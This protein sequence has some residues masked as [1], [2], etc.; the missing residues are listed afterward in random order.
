MMRKK[1]AWVICV[2]ALLVGLVQIQQGTELA[3]ASSPPKTDFKYNNDDIGEYYSI[4]CYGTQNPNK[5]AF[6][7]L[8]ATDKIVTGVNFMYATD[9]TDTTNLQVY[10]TNAYT[11]YWADADVS[12]LMTLSSTA[13]WM[14]F[15]FTEEFI[16]GTS[17]FDVE[18]RSTDD[19][20]SCPMNIVDT[21]STG[22][23][24]HKSFSAWQLDT[25]GE[26]IVEMETEAIQPLSY[27][28]QQTGTINGPISDYIDCWKFTVPSATPLDVKASVTSGSAI[29]FSVYDGYYQLVSSMNKLGD[30]YSNSTWQEYQRAPQA[31][32]VTYYVLVRCVNFL[33][34]VA[35]YSIEYSAQAGGGVTD[36]DYEENDALGSAYILTAGSYPGLVCADDDWYRIYLN[37]GQNLTAYISFTHSLGDLDLKLYNSSGSLLNSSTSVNDWE[38]VSYAAAASG[39]YYVD[40]YRYSGS[41]SNDY[42]MTFSVVGGVS[43]DG[44]EDNDLFGTASPVSQNT[45]SGLVCADDDWYKIYV[46]S[47]N[48]LT[49][50]IAFTHS[51]GDLDLKLWQTESS[52]LNFS[53]STNNWERVTYEITTT[54][55][56]YVQVYRYT[57]SGSNSYTMTLG[58]APSSTDDIYEQNDVLEDAKTLLA[59][60]YSSLVC[61]D[62]DWFKIDVPAY[63]TLRVTVTFSSSGDDL[64]LKIYFASGNVAGVGEISSGTNTASIEVTEGGI[65]YI[66]VFPAGVSNNYSLNISTPPLSGGIAGFD[67]FVLLGVMSIV[68]SILVRKRYNHRN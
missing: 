31:S 2:A 5:V 38:R 23:S 32:S 3:T 66:K 4:F 35:S 10:V 44:F 15:S 47:G 11:S 28:V 16:A 34:G 61:A 63:S 42:D 60:S 1:Y 48:I 53:L 30:S 17:A 40:V 51:L 64:Y 21:G 68:C 59:G 52:Q 39:Y 56:Y 8:G 20:S 62:A 58:I 24:Y 22:H 36:D 14:N 57:G 12:G 37:A 54:G 50:N 19:T 41:G 43:D 55:Y 6:T 9:P 67:V 33:S 18:F 45:Y 25:N 65:Y 13:H 27:M 26:F 49:V 46:T 7:G 29:N